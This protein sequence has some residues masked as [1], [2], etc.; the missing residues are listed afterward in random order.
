MKRSTSTIWRPER[1]RESVKSA[2]QLG[3]R[4][5]PLPGWSHI[6]AEPPQ[7]SWHLLPPNFK[8]RLAAAAATT[9]FTEQARIYL[10]GK[11]SFITKRPC[12]NSLDDSMNDSMEKRIKRISIEGNIGTYSNTF[13]PNEYRL[14]LISENKTHSWRVP[15]WSQ[16]IWNSYRGREVCDCSW[17]NIS[18]E[19]FTAK[20]IRLLW[21]SWCKM[22]RHRFNS[23]LYRVDVTFNRCGLNVGSFCF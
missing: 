5:L 13:P 6:C 21:V 19:I 4:Q 16:C 7:T 2:G 14:K 9:L 11:M 1:W 23:R 22:P 17:G 18:R 12:P 15:R 3:E 20:L 8:R 10:R